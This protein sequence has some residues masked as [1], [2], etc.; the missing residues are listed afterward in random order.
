MNGVCKKLQNALIQFLAPKEFLRNI[1]VVPRGVGGLEHEQ[2]LVTHKGRTLC[3]FHPVPQKL[4][5][6]IGELCIEQISIQLA[7]GADIHDNA[8]L[9]DL[10]EQLAESLH[11]QYFEV[12]PW[13]GVFLLQAKLP[14][15]EIKTGTHH[16]WV[17]MHFLTQ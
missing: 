4:V 7:L 12:P 8:N 2:K 13:A 1:T 9:L 11:G 17:Q 14:W 5:E 16:Q 3:V 15:A 6:N 10:A